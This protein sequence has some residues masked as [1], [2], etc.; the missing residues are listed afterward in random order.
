LL[1][2]AIVGLGNWGQK[3]VAAVNGGSPLLRVDCAVVREARDD[4]CAFARSHDISLATDLQQVLNDQTI[5][6]VIITTPHSLHVQQIIAAAAAGKHVF[7]EKPLA[8]TRE[9]AMRALDACGKAGR[10]L[11]VGHDKRY[12]PSMIALREIASNRA[13]GNILHLEGHTSNENASRFAGWRNDPLETPGGGM[14]GAGVHMLDAL[15]SIAGPVESLRAQLISQTE[16]SAP[17]DSVSALLRFTNG[18][19]GTLATVRSTPFYWRAH[20]FGDAGSAEALGQ[21]CL[22]VRKAGAAL[23][24][25]EFEPVDTLRAEMDAFAQAISGQARPTPSSGEIVATVHA[26]E[27][28]LDSI[29]LKRTVRLH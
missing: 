6:A 26:F 7:C 3:I 8:L 28:M 20:V 14:T 18:I 23:E 17:R 2:A 19:S 15:I 25:R 21:T 12:W 5:D 16:C 11:A 9:D 10:I 4:L 22:V 27:A 29:A 24:R 13:L 1:S